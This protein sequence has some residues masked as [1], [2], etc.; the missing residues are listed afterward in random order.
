L[1]ISCFDSRQKPFLGQQWLLAGDVPALK[2][3]NLRQQQPVKAEHRMAAESPGNA[4][5]V[6]VNTR[7]FTW[8]AYGGY[9]AETGRA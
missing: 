5:M 7:E 4:G 6:I 3:V 9:L 1:P 8:K 2:S